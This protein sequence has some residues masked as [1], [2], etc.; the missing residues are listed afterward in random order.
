MLVTESELVGNG[1]GGREG[2]RGGRGGRGGVKRPPE[3]V[4]VQLTTP[5]YCWLPREAS[6][7]GGG[8]ALHSSHLLLLEVDHLPLTPTHLLEAVMI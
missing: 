7:C 3:Y 5:V 4:S 2:R 8:S 6:Q 1:R